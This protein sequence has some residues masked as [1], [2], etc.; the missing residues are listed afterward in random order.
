MSTEPIY[1]GR[2]RTGR[3]LHIVTERGRAKCSRDI[4]NA[5]PV[6][7]VKPPIDAD[8]CA[9][10]MAEAA[11]EVLIQASLAR[12]P[13]RRQRVPARSAPNAEAER[14][15]ADSEIELGEFM[16]DHLDRHPAPEGSLIAAE[17]RQWGTSLAAHGNARLDALERGDE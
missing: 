17:M 11:K 1:V 12:I 2:S 10:C 6:E 7:A 15:D 8:W 4:G 16:L 9:V 3:R 14:W 13:D 5:T